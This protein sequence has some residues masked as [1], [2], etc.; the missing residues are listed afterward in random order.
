LY[1]LSTTAVGISFMLFVVTLI[2]DLMITTS[3]QLPFDHQRREAIKWAFDVTMLTAAAAYLLRGFVEG[4]KP[5]V[6]NEVSVTIPDFPEDGF[7]IIQL[8]DV[9]VGHTIRRSFMQSIV[10]RVNALQPGLVVITG[11]LFD[12]TAARIAEDLE[13][14]RGIIAPTYFVTGNHEYFRGV[15]PAL[16]MLR[17]LGVI[18]LTNQHRQ[19]VLTQGRFNLLGVNDLVGA[20]FGVE[21]FDIDAAYEG[22]D[23]SLPTVVLSHQPKSIHYFEEQRCDLMLSGHTHGGQIFPFGLLVKLDQPYVAGLYQHN[24]AQQIFVS[25]GTG[26]W[27]PPIRVLAPSEISKITI[28]NR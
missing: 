4:A 19:I 1:R 25:R 26:Y 23:A 5:P 27:G 11:D 18:P 12:R 16:E 13:P 10:A 20:G 22:L 14:L 24:V 2:Y 9:H 7:T 15:T 3:R 17:S 28:R 6:L 21:P 8:S